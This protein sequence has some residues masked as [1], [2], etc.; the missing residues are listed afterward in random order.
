MKKPVVFLDRDGVLTKEKSYVLHKDELEIFDYARA[1]VRKMHNAGYL[2]LVITNQSAVG[3]GMITEETLQE[4]NR[5]L[6]EETGVDDI[7]YCPHWHPTATVCNCRK[8]QIGMIQQAMETYDLDM[9]HAYFVGDRASDIRTGQNAGIKT[10]LLE[11][12]YGTKRLEEEVTPDY[13]FEDL[14]DFVKNSNL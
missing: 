9:E 3:R 11:S 12:G 1:C 13:I 4:M 7:F 2:V 8:P 10:V 6:M 5:I 14:R